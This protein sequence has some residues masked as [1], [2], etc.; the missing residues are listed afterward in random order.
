M[1]DTNPQNLQE[2]A[3]IVHKGA[4][5]AKNARLEIEQQGGKVLTSQNAKQLG[6]RNM[7]KTLPEKWDKDD[8]FLKGDVVC[9]EILSIF[10]HVFFELVFTSWRVWFRWIASS[11]RIYVEK[12]N[13]KTNKDVCPQLT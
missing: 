7:P 12:V 6:K 8:F 5:V 1:V 4:N 2:S 11:C 13:V 9:A 10:A 3:I